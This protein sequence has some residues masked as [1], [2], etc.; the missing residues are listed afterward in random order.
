MPKKLKGNN[1]NKTSRPPVV[2]VMGHVDHG[3]STLLDYIRK[4]NVVEKE[5]G[6]ITQHISAYEVV[7]KREDGIPQKITFLDTP[8]HEAFKAMRE[9]GVAVADIAVLVISAEDG[10]KTQTLE[11]LKTVT[12]AG[13]PYLVAINKIDKP[14]ANLEKTKQNLAE[15]GIYVEGFG[16]SISVVPISAKTGENVNQLLDMILLISDLEELRGN[17]NVGAEGVVIESNLDP[18]KGVTATVVIKNGTLVNDECVVAGEAIASLRMMENFLGEKINKAT[19]S[20]PVR[21]IGWSQLPEVGSKVLGCK[22]KKEAEVAASLVKERKFQEKRADVAI[23]EGT[24]IIPIIIKTDVAGMADAIRDQISKLHTGKVFLK[25][26]SS[27]AGTISE[28]DVKTALPFPGAIIVGFNVKTESSANE[29]A[30][31]HNIE[32]KPFNVIYKLTEY[33]AEVIS[34]RTPKIQSEEVRGALKILKVFSQTKDKQVI[35]GKILNGAVVTHDKVRVMRRDN[36]IGR[37]EILELQQGKS[38]VKEVLNGECGIQVEAKVTIAPG[39]TLE[40]I[41]LVTK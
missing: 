3:K 32:I 11:A 39:D 4:T 23:P 8:G 28:N 15:N 30:L 7:H 20:S 9:R 18:K 24:V 35:G 16:G 31:R 13:I 12:E 22:N 6:G 40:S 10:V 5:F 26:L 19:F 14:N 34:Q 38:K 17:K 21:I 1:E 37:G 25:I 27:S 36:E 41:A 33:F 2:V 29:L